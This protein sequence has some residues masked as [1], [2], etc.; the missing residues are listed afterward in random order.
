MSNDQ[1]D[2]EETD[3]EVREEQ[4]SDIEQDVSDSEE[5]YLFSTNLS[6]IGKHTINTYSFF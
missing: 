2:Q 4:H 1:S 3:F 5:S 6:F